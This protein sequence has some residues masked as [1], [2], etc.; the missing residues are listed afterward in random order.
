MD[1]TTLK[2]E[3]LNEFLPFIQKT[4][5]GK[6]INDKLKIS[7]SIGLFIAEAV[8]LEKAAQLAGKSLADFIEMLISKN[9]FWHDYKEENLKSDNQ[10]IQKYLLLSAND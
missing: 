10:A 8:S 3:S 2:T 9:I 5:L 1:N 7:L 6:N 4:D